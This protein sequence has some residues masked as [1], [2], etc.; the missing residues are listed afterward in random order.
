VRSVVTACS[1]SFVDVE[2]RPE[3]GAEI[4]SAVLEIFRDGFGILGWSREGVAKTLSRCTLLGLLHSEEGSIEGYAFYLMVPGPR[5]GTWVLW[6]DAICLRKRVQRSGYARLILGELMTRDASSPIG[7]VGG[8]TQNPAVMRRYCGLGSCFPFDRF[9]DVRDGVA[10]M[11]VLR[12]LVPEVSDAPSGD[13][14]TGICRGVYSERT[15]GDYAW[16]SEGR[17]ERALTAWGFQRERGDAV[18]TVAE[19]GQAHVE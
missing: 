15:L 8:R 4:V 19:V 16:R 1:W 9:W 18:I 11:S 17:F 2:A 10:L 12:R 3:E 14:R 7:W 6:E 13:P 5:T